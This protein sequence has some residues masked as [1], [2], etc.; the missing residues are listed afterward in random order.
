VPPTEDQVTRVGALIHEMTAAGVLIAI[1]GC[2]PTRH[3]A[4]IQL[5]AGELRV[6]DGPFT[7]V[8]QV[9]SGVLL[10]QTKSKADAVHWGKRLLTILGEGSVELRLLANVV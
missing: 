2:L 6:V 10:L 5:D 9:V 4:R 3:G 7:D 8:K 1:E